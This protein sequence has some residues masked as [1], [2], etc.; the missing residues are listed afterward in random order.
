MV[1]YYMNGYVY[2]LVEIDKNGEERY[3]IGVTKRS[4]EKRIRELQTGNS[5]LVRLLQVYESVNYK[6]VEQWLH[7]RLSGQ[8]T[9]ANN[10]FFHLTDDQVFG[11][12]DTCKK[13]DETIQLLK[14]NPFF[15]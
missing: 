10:E 1:I 8:K 7:S 13:L 5:G 11:F 6:K 12:I 2:L 14:D 3:K 15:K 9:E 4:P